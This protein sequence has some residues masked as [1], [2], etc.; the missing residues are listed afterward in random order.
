M[1]TNQAPQMKN[2]RNIIALSFTRTAGDR[3]GLISEPPPPLA[4]A[5]AAEMPRAHARAVAAMGE[6]LPQAATLSRRFALAG[7]TAPAIAS[8]VEEIIMQSRSTVLALSLALAGLATARVA[9]AAE[10]AAGVH[11]ALQRARPLRLEGAGRGQRP[12]E[13]GGRR[14][15]LRRA[16]RGQRRQ[17]PLDGE[18]VRRLRAARRVADQ[19]DARTQ[20][21]RADHPLR[22][23]ATRRARTARRSR[24]RCPTPTRGIYLRGSSKSQVNIWCWPIG[25]GEV[26]GYR[27]DEK[28]PAAVRAGV[29]PKGNADKDVGEWNA[30]EITMKGD[31][32]TVVLNGDHG[33]RER[34]AAGRARAKGPI[35]PAAP[36]RRRR[37]ASG[38]ARPR[39]SSSATLSIKEL[40]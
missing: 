18:G 2:W 29:T 12:L 19:G 30:F 4:P 25:S 31:R 23:H 6:N 21:Q 1:V 14:H 27:M 39:S 20:P 13:G 35:A 3:V 8:R 26:Y 32:L 37:T 5:I 16:E 33:H 10:P 7:K 17:E 28:M 11:V 40:K 22:R 24:S 38:P 9:A 36:R 34:A 15:R